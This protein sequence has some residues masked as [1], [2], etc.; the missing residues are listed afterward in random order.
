MTFRE[1][2]L[3]LFAAD[4]AGFARAAAPLRP[5]EVAASLENWY[6][7]LETA[8]TAHGGG[9]VKYM[10][11]GCLATFPPEGCAAAVEAAIQLRGYRSPS[12]YVE[13]GVTIHLGTVAEGTIGR[14]RRYDVFGAAVNDLFRM[15]RAGAVVISEPVYQRLP[16]ELRARWQSRPAPPTYALVG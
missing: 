4:L 2:E 16:P 6:R 9:L 7:A 11:D 13:V 5:L 1:T 15:E 3:V 12:L 14:D 8:L 10:G